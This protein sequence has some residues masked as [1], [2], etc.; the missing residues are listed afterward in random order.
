M[1]EDTPARRGCG[2]AQTRV[3]DDVPAERCEMSADLA[4]VIEP[5]AIGASWTRP[6]F[7]LRTVVSILDA[8]DGR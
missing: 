8:G 1:S 2:L 5:A 3:D 4:A 7:A 6:A